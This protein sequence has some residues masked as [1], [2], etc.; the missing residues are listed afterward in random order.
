M[1]PAPRSRLR[2]ALDVS[3]P[4]LRQHDWLTSGKEFL[5]RIGRV[6]GVGGWELE[7]ATGT[8]RWSPETFR[9]HGVAAD[10][11]PDV[12]TAIAFYAPE[13]RPVI[14]AAVERSIASG[15]GWDL[16]LPFTRADGTPIWVRAAGIV[17]FVE[18][19]ATCLIGT[20]QDVTEQ[21][22]ARRALQDANERIGLATA[23]GRIGIWEWE[24]T[25]GRVTWDTWMYRLYGME[26]QSAPPD[27]EQWISFLHPDDA[28][29]A[30]SEVRNAAAGL[31][32]FDTEFRVIWTDG[33][34]HHIR[35][36]G[37]VSRDGAGRAVRMVGANWDVTGS[38]RLEADLTR[39]L[40]L[41]AEAAE[42]ERAVFRNSSDALYIVGVR[43]MPHGPE[44]VF[45]AVS[46][47]MARVT[48][49]DPAWLVGQTPQD[50]LPPNM[51][52]TKVQ[53]LKE[54]VERGVTVLFAETYQTPL[55][56]RDIESTLTPIRHA[57]TGAVVRLAG[58]LRDVTERNQGRMR[59]M[60]STR[61]SALGT[62]A[63]GIAH[64]INNPLTVIHALAG[65]LA[66]DAE[67]GEVAAPHVL[68]AAQ[69]IARMSDRI[70]KI[71]K[72]L[73][74]I[75]RDAGEDALMDAPLAGIVEQALEVCTKRFELES[76]RL[77]VAAIDSVL[78]VTCREV[79]I[80][81]VLVNLLQNALDAAA[82]QES[83]RWVRLDVSARAGQAV[84][85]V[86][87]SG[88]GVPPELR[89]RIMTPFFTTKPVGR[90]TGLGLSLSR[91]I[92]EAHGGSVELGEREGRTCFSLTIP[93]SEGARSP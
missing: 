15:E 55:G 80:A 46:P 73:R 69:R 23:S 66:D 62:M 79:Q 84:V 18:S 49:L 70:G 54:C 2:Q 27:F 20:F 44:F 39:Q 50:A 31:E 64:E 92:A 16:E 57:A 71:V 76:V 72:S 82:E 28:E 81:Q 40:E 22:R 63:G 25:T 88:R 1:G 86:T 26:T 52:Q 47:A 68:Q 53:H 60:A 59:M 10:F 78:Q 14:R 91:Q 48:G 32:P 65:E 21:V 5:E 51:A 74:Y 12:D 13:A 37:R 42:R 11:T 6:A 93:L 61:L 19:R 34:V 29:R 7:L 77:D 38:R 33:S 4:P 89:E 43:D 30:H 83:E 90:G 45:E 67:M 56:P 87:D 8:L 36:T 41:Q 17:E 24:I 35:G 9:I 75:A 85:S 3:E 58:S